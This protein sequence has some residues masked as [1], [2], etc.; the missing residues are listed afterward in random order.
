MENIIVAFSNFP[1]VLPLHTSYTHNDIF[2][3][4]NYLW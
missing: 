1:C 3:T 4:K 2:T